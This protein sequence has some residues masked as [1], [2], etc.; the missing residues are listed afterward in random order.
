MKAAS[1]NT[2]QED[3]FSTIEDRGRAHWVRVIRSRMA[4]RSR[5]RHRTP[6]ILT[7]R[8]NTTVNLRTTHKNGSAAFPNEA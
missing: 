7:S 5:C 8:P 4:V 6:P 1:E 3:L 2:L